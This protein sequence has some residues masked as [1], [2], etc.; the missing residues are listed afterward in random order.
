MANRHLIYTL[1]QKAHPI[2]SYEDIKNVSCAQSTFSLRTHTLETNCGGLT[3]QDG[4][5]GDEG[6]G[7]T[8]SGE[9]R[10]TSP[11]LV[12]TILSLDQL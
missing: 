3:K 6:V 11:L 10:F 4:E 12:D 5:V 7:A 8:T 1:S 9:C 2:G